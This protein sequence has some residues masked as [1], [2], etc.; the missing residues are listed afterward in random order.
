MSLLIEYL[1]E[2]GRFQRNAR[3]YLI[4]NI[5]SGVTTGS[6]LIL[7]NLY[8]VSLGYKTDFIG[9]LYLMGAVGIGI[10]IFPAGLCVDRFG[11]KSILI[12][13][14][15]AIGVFG[16][17]QL[18]FR[19]P[20]PLLISTFFVGLAAAFPFVVNAP[21][22]T[23]NSTRAERPQLFS[24]NIV[25]ILATT[26]IG[27]VLGGALPIWLRQQPWLMSAFPHWLNWALVGQ[28][29]PRSY[30]LAMLLAGII[31]APSFIPLFLMDDDR[32][33]TRERLS[34]TTV[35]ERESLRMMLLMLRRA[36]AHPK[37]ILISPFSMLLLVQIVVAFG[38]GLIIPYFN[39]YFVQHLKA[40][41]ALFGLIDGG[42][43]TINAILTLLAPLLAARIGRINTITITRLCSL[44][45]L[46]IIGFTTT[47]PLAAA[48]Y[49]FRQG[50][51]DMGLGLFQ[52]Y[53][54]EAIPEQRRGLA[55][56]SYQ[57]AMNVP[58]A[59]STPLGG[60]IIAQMGYRPVFIGTA[61][62][63]ALAI[64][65]LWLRFRNSSPLRRDGGRAQAGPYD[66]EKS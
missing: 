48:L 43:N 44:P 61:I 37:K 19:Q 45:L 40:S 34:S 60:L 54:M 16:A 18:L 4:S 64:L 50:T 9:L 29:Q 55:N 57:V 56:S 7:Y 52:V 63:Y 13:S 22:L 1:R 5:L 65:A 49:L 3:L 21:F 8:L 32:P 24:I 39:L 66:E 62:L 53:S 28:V 25:V 14:S 58:M 42:A 41:S 27:E 15:A 30:Q 51:M 26:V 11:G 36:L 17:A 38:A 33:A 2:F 10:A 20:L 35:D 59:L 23:N 12:W 46:L 47:L 6:I 31:A